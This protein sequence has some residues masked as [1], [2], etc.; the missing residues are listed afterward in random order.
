MTLFVLFIAIAFTA[1]EKTQNKEKAEVKNTNT[2]SENVEIYY[3]HGTR[4]CVTCVA[5]G[6]VAANLVADK[7]GKNPNVKFIEINIDESAPGIEELA[8]KFKVTGSGLY[9]YNGEN[10]ENITA[11]AFQKAISAPDQLEKKL[12]ELIDKNL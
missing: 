12:I 8:E 7:Y 6:D 2:I 5:V 10:I 1:C 3:F 4:R 9:V 11:L